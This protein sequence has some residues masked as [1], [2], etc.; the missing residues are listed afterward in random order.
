ML[1]VRYLLTEIAVFVGPS[2]AA[3]AQQ[4]GAHWQLI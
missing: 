2:N 1:H 4:C 3:D